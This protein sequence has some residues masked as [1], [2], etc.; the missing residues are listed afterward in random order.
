[1][2][3]TRDGN[4]VKEHKDGNVTT[5][6]TVELNVTGHMPSNF[7]PEVECAQEHNKAVVTIRFPRTEYYVRV[8]VIPYKEG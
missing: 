8:E 6:N 4:N 1:M 7:Y 2:N 5:H 3:S